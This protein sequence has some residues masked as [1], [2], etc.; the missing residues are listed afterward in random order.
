MKSVI[1]NK[2]L[3]EDILAQRQRALS[4]VVPGAGR[5]GATNYAVTKKDILVAREEMQ[6]ARGKARVE[7]QRRYIA[8]HHQFAHQNKG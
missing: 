5:V 6:N 4:S 8:V 7:A 3:R 1:T 2:E